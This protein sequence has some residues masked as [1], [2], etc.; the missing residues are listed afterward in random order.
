MRRRARQVALLVVAVMLAHLASMTVAPMAMHAT[1]GDPPRSHAGAHHAAPDSSSVGNL[2]AVQD[3]ATCFA[4]GELATFSRAPLPPLVG[5]A[6]LPV[7]MRLEL[8]A[9]DLRRDA[10]PEPPPPDAAMRRALLQVFLN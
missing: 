2:A 1:A 3:A 9:A 4:T 8:C 6:A 7:D 5:F 10:H